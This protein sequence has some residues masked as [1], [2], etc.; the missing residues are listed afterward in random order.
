MG[1]LFDDFDLDIQKVSSGGFGAEARQTFGGSHCQT[2][3]GPFSFNCP[4][5]TFECAPPDSWGPVCQ[6]N[7]INICGG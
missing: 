7:S 5:P 1:N 4:C 6:G 2:C 3:N